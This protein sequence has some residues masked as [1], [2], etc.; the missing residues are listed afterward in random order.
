MNQVHQTEEISEALRIFQKVTNLPISGNLS[1]ATLAMMKQPR[2][3]IQDFFTDNSLKYRFI[4]SIWRKKR[5]TY[6]IY[7]YTPDLGLAKTRAAIQSAFRYWTEVSPLTF[8]EVLFPA[9]ADIKISFHKKDK[10]CP[11]PFD[12]PGGVL[13]HAD[14]P[15]SGIVHFD[16]DE[17][18]TEGKSSS[19]PNLRIV[20]AHEIGHALGLGHSQYNSALMGPVYS[21]YR[22]KFKLHS[23]D[24]L[25]IQRLYGKPKTPPT[26]SR[27]PNEPSS[28]AG[29][30]DPCK[31]TM[32]AIMLGPLRKTYMFSGQ[33]V[34]TVSD[35][36]GY[37]KPILISVLWKDLPGSL[38]AAVHSQKT[39]KSYFLKGDKVWRYSRFKLDIGFPKFL[40]SIPSNVDSALYVNRKVIFFKGSQYW[41]WDEAR[42]VD[43]KKYPKPISHLFSGVPYNLDAAFTWTNGYVYVFKGDQYWR[44]KN[45]NVDKGYPLKTSVKWMQCDD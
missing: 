27:K 32:D 23:D 39:N 41:E 1:E 29:P 19:G 20:A 25:G 16:E 31:G 22:D 7:N 12:G 38:N 37:T 13:A 26:V 18:W 42:T 34:W 10:S 35:K 17:Q 4:G 2:C 3:G 43:L 40:A 36:D 45:N 14:N 6:R 8:H 24:I 28:E 44:V 33:Y 9:R 15:E 5:L 21:G 30:P 11:V